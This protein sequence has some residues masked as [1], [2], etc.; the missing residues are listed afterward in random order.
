L[1][2]A[3][4]HNPKSG[5]ARRT[6]GMYYANAGRL[7]DAQAMLASGLKGY[8]SALQNVRWFTSLWPIKEPQLVK[9][10]AEGYIKAGLSGESNDFYKISSENRLSGAELR[11]LF[12]GRKVTGFT[13]ATG[14]QWWVDR[15]KD[16]KATILNNDKSDSGK[17]WI[18]DDVLCDQWDNFYENL[19]DCWV[20]YRNPEGTP[21][22]NDEYLGVP[23]YGVFP[24]SLVK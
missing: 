17:S 1:E 23:G 6:L 10:F 5:A 19:K 11:K 3:V 8:P 12:F 15:S 4:A 22:N 9:R 16:G 18:E 13:L 21:E 7:Q 20:V 14:N 2:K 24:F